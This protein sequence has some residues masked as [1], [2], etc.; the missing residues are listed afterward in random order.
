MYESFDSNF[1]FALDS[2]ISKDSKD[3]MNQAAQAK[4]PQL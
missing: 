2:R 4:I 1:H 3:M